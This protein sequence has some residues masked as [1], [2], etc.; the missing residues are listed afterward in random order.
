MTSIEFRHRLAAELRM[1]QL[2][3]SPTV[4]AECASRAAIVGDA[5]LADVE[6]LAGIRT[7]RR[8]LA[9]RRGPQY[10]TTYR[11]V[12]GYG[13]LMTEFLAAP[14][15]LA[16]DDRARVAR[17]GALA[18]LIVSHFDELVDGG[19]P[20][21]FLLPR[22]VLVLS[23]KGRGRTILRIGTAIAPSP[24]RLI[25]RMV[26][27]YFRR[28]AALPFADRHDAARSQL[29]RAVSE[30]YEEEGRTPRELRRVRGNAA[31]QKKTALP[32]VVLGMAAW[33]ASPQ[34]P[35]ST[36]AH[37]RRWLMRV[38]KFIRWIDDAADLT[39]DEAAGASNLVRQALR[40]RTAAPCAGEQLACGIAR[41]G[42]RVLE[43]WREMS[44]ASSSHESG[45]VFETVLA[46][47]MGEP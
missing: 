47:W 8:A 37:H 45:A 16:P 38:G 20:R 39:D 19:W 3:G 36:Y 27:E 9:I 26:G 44:G 35:A 10:A 29:R 5:A 46:A 17:L 14:V 25:V 7:T 12:A 11:Y 34:C 15:P 6:R 31:R 21:P 40:R 28:V 30:M 24:S 13:A 43:E 41:R 4:R 42:R 1:Q 32:L 2:F 33:L 23:A 18:N 22:W